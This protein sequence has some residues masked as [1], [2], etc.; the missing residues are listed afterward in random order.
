MNKEE[1]TDDK[2]VFND[3]IEDF[4]DENLKNEFLKVVDEMTNRGL[5]FKDL[6]DYMR[7]GLRTE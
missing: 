3:D 2:E 4:T 7:N 5:T 1:F 6:E